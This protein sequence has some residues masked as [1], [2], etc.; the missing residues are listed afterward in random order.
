M[1]V[2]RSTSTSAEGGAGAGAGS[3]YRRWG[4]SDAVD[5]PS[6][7]MP[8]AFGGSRTSARREEDAR[9]A[10]DEHRDA[11]EKS[12][13]AKAEV[14]RQ[15]K[16]RD[17]TDTEQYPTLSGG[18]GAA[19]PNKAKIQLNFRDMAHEAAARSTLAEAEAA[20]AAKRRELEA[21]RLTYSETSTSRRLYRHGSYDDGPVDHNFP[22]EEGYYQPDEEVSHPYNIDEDEDEDAVEAS[23]HT[24]AELNPHLAVIRRRGDKGDW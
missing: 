2:R 8:S 24:E 17:F 21:A 19:A 12:R 16:I 1:T 22:D 18:G 9:R 5:G 13:A 20:A 6:R 7:D 3:G 14:T 11:T 15:A 10:W 23:A 4:S